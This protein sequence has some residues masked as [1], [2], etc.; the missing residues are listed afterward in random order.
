VVVVPV[1]GFVYFARDGPSTGKS[2]ALSDGSTCISFDP[3]FPVSGS[4]GTKA[5]R[6]TATI[7]KAVKPENVRARIL[8]KVV[9]IDPPGSI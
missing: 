7:K 1:T 8:R 5:T 2:E 4:V 9:V 6:I 3:A